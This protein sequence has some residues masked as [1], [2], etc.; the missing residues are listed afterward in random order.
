MVTGRWCCGARPASTDAATKPLKHAGAA[1]R[2]DI[3]RWPAQQ[4]QQQLDL[5]QRDWAAANAGSVAM[6][7]ALGFLDRRA[8]SAALTACGGVVDH[9]ADLL[10][11][12]LESV[13]GKERQQTHDRGS[14]GQICGLRCSVRPVAALAYE[15]LVEEE[16]PAPIDDAPLLPPQLLALPGRGCAEC[17]GT[18]AATEG[19]RDRG[20]SL[21]FAR[22]RV[23][24]VAVHHCRHCGSSWDMTWR[25]G[26]PD[27]RAGPYADHALVLQ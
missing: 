15:A 18:D 22:W 6:L 21:A 17:L 11:A 26:R 23:P 1:R 7:E 14:T 3:A 12:Q 20:A 25:D 9:A 8:T 5:G 27:T 4:R 19:T 13:D 24:G 10:L 16:E 2:A